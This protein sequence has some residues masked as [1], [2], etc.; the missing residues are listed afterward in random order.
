MALRSRKSTETSPSTARDSA[1][2]ARLPALSGAP[3]AS[4]EAQDDPFLTEFEREIGLGEPEKTAEMAEKV[5]GDTGISPFYAKKQQEQ[6]KFREKMQE[7]SARMA[8][9]KVPASVEPLMQ[10]RTHSDEAV[11]LLRL[12]REAS[13]AFD[14][15]VP[16]L[17]F[18][19]AEQARLLERKVQALRG[20]EGEEFSGDFDLQVEITQQL[21][22][23]REMRTRAMSEG[24]SVREMKEVMTGASSLITT[25]IREQEKVINMDRLR[26]VEQ[27]VVECLKTL[28]D[29]VQQAFMKKMEGLLDGYDRRQGEPG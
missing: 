22:L 1:T 17:E 7:T 28:P 18:L 25:L 2:P 8:E 9:S 13:D 29:D 19:T 12:Q 4:R 6:A 5:L 26:Y 21:R 27:A 3:V 16:R 23:L 11:Q 15:L 20:T 10:V 14:A 24:S